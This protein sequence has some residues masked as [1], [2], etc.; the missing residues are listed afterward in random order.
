M[1]HKLGVDRFRLLL[2]VRRHVEDAHDAARQIPLHVLRIDHNFVVL[3][4]PVVGLQRFLKLMGWEGAI[5]YS[6]WRARILA[7]LVQMAHG[8][9]ISGKYAMEAIQRWRSEHEACLPFATVEH[10]VVVPVDDARWPNATEFG[11]PEM[12]CARLPCEA[13]LA[14]RIKLPHDDPGFRHISARLAVSPPQIYSLESVGWRRRRRW[15]PRRWQRQRR[16]PRQRAKRAGRAR[17]E[18]AMRRNKGRLAI[19]CA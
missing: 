9:P 7:W 8:V 6:R 19:S 12:I 4:I 10:V 3:A 17:T 16:R 11:T 2:G 18:W 5:P 13:R 14:E 1:S 15:R